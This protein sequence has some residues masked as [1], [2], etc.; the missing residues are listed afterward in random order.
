MNMCVYGKRSTRTCIPAVFITAPHWKQS[1]HLPTGEWISQLK[2]IPTMECYSAFRKERPTEVCKTRVNLKN[3]LLNEKSQIQKST[4][5]MSPYAW[6]LGTNR[7]YLVLI[8]IRKQ[9]PRVGA[10]GRNWLE[11]A[12]RELA[13]A[14]EMFNILFFWKVLQWPRTVVS[15][16]RTGHLPSV[17]FMIS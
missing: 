9:L 8:E 17:H 10:G 2:H 11:R 4:H 13:G 15:I 3:I 5:C 14:M 6:N 16:H 1:R 7:A 12:A